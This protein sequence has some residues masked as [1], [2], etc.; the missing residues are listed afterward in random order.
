MIGSSNPGECNTL[1]GNTGANLTVIGDGVTVQG[2]ETAYPAW[3]AES[4]S[5]LHPA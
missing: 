1:S 2:N 4:W 5:T 3:E